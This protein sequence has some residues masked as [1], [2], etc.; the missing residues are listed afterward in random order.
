M[1]VHELLDTQYGSDGDATL[2]RMLDRTDPDARDDAG[3]TPLLVATRRCRPSAVAILLDLGASIDLR[4]SG[5][6]TA[7]AH[8]ARRGFDEV[9]D[10]LQQRGCDRT[11]NEADRLGVALSGGRLDAAQEILAA[12]PGAARTGNPEEDRLLADMA[13]RNDPEPV[14]L[15][16]GAGADLTARGLDDGTPLHQAAWF[17]QPRNARLL[18]D[19]GAAVDV[20]EA[21]HQ[22]SPIGWVTHGS[23]YSGGAAQRQDRYVELARLLL[24]AG[25]SLAYPDEPPSNS[26]RDR[27][28]R[29]A[30][31]AVRALLEQ[32]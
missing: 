10:L 2:R 11:L 21:V 30:S 8:A 25:C 4:S 3:D 12:S 20:F 31:P 5:G 9:A 32:A 17:G 29:D 26:Y 16:I 19:A 22:C 14:A 1:T 15:L 27:L 13:G 6:K 28:L 18:I 7:Y 23:R 24:E